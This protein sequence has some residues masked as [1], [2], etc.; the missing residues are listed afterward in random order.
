[1]EFITLENTTSFMIK[2][3]IWKPLFKSRAN[4][5]YFDPNLRT[6]YETDLRNRLF[7]DNDDKIVIIENSYP[8][9]YEKEI[10]QYVAWIRTNDDPGIDHIKELVEKKF[11]GKDYI[12]HINKPSH[13]SIQ[14]ILH[15]HAIIR[16][17]VPVFHLK[18]LVIFHRHANRDPI[19]KFAPFEKILGN[20]YTTRLDDNPPLLPIGKLNSVKF[21]TDLKNIYQ[22][23]DDFLDNAIFFTSP[24]IRCKE[25]SIN[26]INGLGI[27][28]DVF[29]MNELLTFAQNVVRA[30]NQLPL[31]GPELIN[32]FNKYEILLNKLNRLF[33]RSIKI[34]DLSVSQK[35]ML[36]TCFYDYHSTIECYKDKGID[37]KNFLNNLE[38]QL[39]TAT[40][41]IY[42][43]LNHHY[44]LLLQ[45]DLDNLVTEIIKNNNSLIMCS[46]H[47][48]II[49]LLAKY[50]AHINDINFNLGLPDYLS[51]VRIEEWSDG[52]TRVFY[53]N[54]YLGNKY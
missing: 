23:S 15:Y 2:K 44:Q 46:T 10:S 33:E 29:Q 7:S 21:G 32:T 17:P 41:E 20:K 25:T 48:T 4:D 47:D 22:F 9:N 39:L 12:I 43:L 26:I 16:D 37:T 5:N 54:Y 1:M 28:N 14:N 6:E 13:R 38:E 19:I 51:N 30:L 40:H 53:N 42:N 34:T 18:K 36:L 35:I 27:K 45:K 49:F 50:L 24:K 31:T 3:G 52:Q 8:F 11:P